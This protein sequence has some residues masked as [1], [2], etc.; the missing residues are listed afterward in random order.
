M[1][2]AKTRRFLRLTLCTIGCISGLAITIY[3]VFNWGGALFSSGTYS[4][5]ADPTMEPQNRRLVIFGLILFGFS[6]FAL[7][8]AW[9]D[10]LGMRSR[11]DE[12]DI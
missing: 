5:A 12:G 4:S 6:V 2:T 10:S 7:T 8:R 11:D 9:S 1:N 3:A